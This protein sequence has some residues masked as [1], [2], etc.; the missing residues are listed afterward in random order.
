[1]KHYCRAGGPYWNPLTGPF[2]A[3]RVSLCQ[4]LEHRRV[5]PFSD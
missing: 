1:M 3:L 2:R 4:A 5:V